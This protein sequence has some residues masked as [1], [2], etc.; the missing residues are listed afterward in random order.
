MPP[1]NPQVITLTATS[2]ASYLYRSAD[3]G[4]TW[5]MATY[6]DGGLG[7]RDLAYAAATTGYL[8]H[9]SGG[10]V[11]AYGKGLMKTTNAGANWKA[12]P[13]P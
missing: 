12:I 11:I 3:S 9:F 2:G 10:P 8:I 5:K 1:G 4:K 7:F 13:I 6:F